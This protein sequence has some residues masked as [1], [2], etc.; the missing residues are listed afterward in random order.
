MNT[1]Y[2]GDNLEILRR[3]IDAESVDLIYLDPP[4]NSKRAYNVIFQDKT[5]QD[6]AA[7]IE[8]FE[9]TWTWSAETQSAFDEIMKGGYSGDLKNMMKAFREFMGINNLMAYL[10]MMA[11]R[12]V[13]LHRVLKSTGSIFLHCDPTASHY[14]KILMDQIFG[15]KNYRNEIIWNRTSAH[16]G[17]NRCGPIHDILLFYT[18]S[19][20]YT[21]NN[22][23]Q[24]YDEEYIDTF[25]DEVDEQGKC[26]KRA[27]LTGA[28]ISRGVS[29]NNWRGI[30]VT[31]K[32]RHW[33]HPPDV[34]EELDS[35]GKIHWP[36]KKDGM[37]RLKQYPSDL[38]GVPLQDIWYDIRPLH[39]L[40][41]ERLHYPTQKPVALL[42][43]IVQ[44]SSN[45]GDIVLDP[46]CGCGT[47]VV[48]AEGLNRKWIGIDLTHLA[49]ALIKKR[50][51]DN[52]PGTHYTIVGEPKSV[53]DAQQLFKQSPFQFEAWAVSLIGGQPFKSK[54]GG[55]RGIDG[56]IFFEDAKSKFYRLIVEVKGGSYHPKDVRSLKSVMDRENAPLGILIALESPT[57]GMISEAAAMGTWQ[58]PGVERKFPILQIITIEDLFSGKMPILPEWHKTLKEANRAVREREKNLKLL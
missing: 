37:P 49:I 32:G 15:T 19:N 20:T 57:P 39:N 10:T 48:A 55:D 11:I 21:W 2:Y 25:F 26:Y 29:G 4:F 41:A 5:G 47:A 44:V 7:Q 40:A 36:K 52:F 24:A 14:L 22:V 3:H 23:F 35:K 30:D 9:D 38:P 13:E 46:F 8:A 33:M 54:G 28:G 6:S 58:L 16:S 50:L 56:L 53:Y 42:D 34:L 43:R 45:E 18:K 27:D 51:D 1:L 31:A 12:L 17:A